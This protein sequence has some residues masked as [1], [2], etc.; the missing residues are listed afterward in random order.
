MLSSIQPDWHWPI[1]QLRL[2]SQ[3][4]VTFRYPGESAGPEEAKAALDVCIAM[5]DR[6]HEIINKLKS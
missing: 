6:L 1:E 4:A 2:L 3:A 5:K